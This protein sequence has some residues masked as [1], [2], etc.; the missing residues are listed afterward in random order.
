MKFRT[1]VPELQQTQQQPMFDAPGPE[2]QHSNNRRHDHERDCP[3]D[4]NPK[5]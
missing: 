1:Y 2:L 5:A 4:I 3:L